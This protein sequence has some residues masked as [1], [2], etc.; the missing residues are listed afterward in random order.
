MVCGVFVCE[1][2]HALR[3]GNKLV[4]DGMHEVEVVAICGEPVSRRDLG[5][6]LRY[7]DP[8]YDRRGIQYYTQYYGYGTRRELLVTEMVFNFGPH[9]LMRIMRFEG[10][11]LAS[12]E[13]AGYGFR[14]RSSR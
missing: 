8:Y 4:K 7:Y 5:Y 13:T 9:K 1:S 12:I 3:C 10:G 11:R 2:A 14:E 6:V